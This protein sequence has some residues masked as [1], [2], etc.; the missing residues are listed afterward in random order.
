MTEWHH[1]VD[2]SHYQAKPWFPWDAVAKTSQFVIVKFSEGVRA[3]TEAEALV[4]RAR[5]VGLAVGGYHFWHDGIAPQA[6]LD[7]FAAVSDRCGIRPGDLLPA[8]DLED[9]PHGKLTRASSEP[10]EEWCQGATSLWG[11]V[12]LYINQV[13][14]AEL[15]S[16]AWCLA[17]QLWVAHWPGHT[18]TSPATPDHRP[19][20]IWQYAVHPYAPGS[21]TVTNGDPQ[22]IDHNWARDPLPLIAEP[23]DV[24]PE[25]YIALHPPSYLTQ[26]DWEEFRR[27]RNA[28]LKG[29]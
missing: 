8:L 22:N 20:R 29:H 14:W 7:A 13:D 28:E 5:D 9:P 17:C 23:G 6:Q 18:L 15:G 11:D 1:G 24:A 3:D 10:A 19:W 16:P 4:R 21:W 25:P 2:V 27:M 26:I 12:T